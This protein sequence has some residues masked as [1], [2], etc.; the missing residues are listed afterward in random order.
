MSCTLRDA[1]KKV[2]EGRDL[3]PEE[4]EGA[5]EE[6]ISGSPPPSVVGA[7]LAAM[8]TKGETVEE[9][10]AFARVMHRHSLKVRPGVD[11]VLVD[12]CGTGGDTVKTLNVSTAAMFVA[13]GAGVL[14]AKHGNRAVTGKVGSADLLEAIGARIDLPPR[15]VE[16][17]IERVGVG[18]MFAPRF[19]PATG[20]VAVVRRELGFRTVFNLLGPLTNPAGVKAQLLGVCAQDLTE[21]M[22]LALR[23]LG[24]S[25]AMVVY[26]MNGVDEISAT[27]ETLVT[28]LCGGRISSRVVRPEDFG[29]ERVGEEQVRGGDLRTNVRAFLN[30]LSGAGGGARGMVL[31]NAGAA[32]YLGEKADSLREGVA[33]AA[34]SVDSGSAYRKLREF[35]RATGG[36]LEK[37]RMWEESI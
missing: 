21:K 25:K 34:E 29:I 35:V 13:A 17:C 4:A 30:V 18:F 28:E 15:E 27:H 24:R 33:L 22:A 16:R 8:R 10:V 2:V 7:F 37:L 26:G 11:G 23:E 12:T 31:L 20:N 19:H 1:L 5:M 9:M 14:I 36:D 3:H 6:M 32:I